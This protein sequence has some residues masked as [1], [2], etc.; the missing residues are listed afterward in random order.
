MRMVNSM[1]GY[2]R[3]VEREGGREITAELRSVNQRG[4]E[5]S[6]RLPRGAAFLEDGLRH[7]VQERVTRGKVELNVNIAG[8]TGVEVAAD[9]RLAEAY[10]ATVRALAESHGLRD[11][12]AASDL[13]RLDGLFTVVKPPEDEDALRTVV[14]RAVAGALDAFCAMRAAEGARLADDI[15]ARLDTIET[16]LTR[17][18]ERAPERVAEYRDRLRARMAEVLAETGVDENRIL[19]EAALYADRV[20]VDEETVRLRSHIA[21]FRALLADEQPAGRK[22]DFLVQEMGREINTIGSK[23]NDL[24]LTNLVI[25]MKTEMEKIREQAQN[26]E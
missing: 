9:P 13:L 7:L 22:P 17:V 3:A 6:A 11:D 19:A 14:E 1:T 23:S 2:G 25:L 16:A 18:E 26:I 21:Q 8:E 10:L 20:A 15:T 5:F 12:L 4:L 24:T